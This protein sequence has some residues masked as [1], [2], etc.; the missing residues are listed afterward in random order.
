[1]SWPVPISLFPGGRTQSVNVQLIPPGTKF[2]DRWNQ[3][4]VSVNK[5]F[6]RGRVKLRPKVE[7]FNVL[8]SS[9][10]LAELQTF[11]TSLGKPSETLQGR[12]VKLGA[13]VTF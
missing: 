1:M 5:T 8:N 13:S 4:D 7:V 6:T 11:G 9:V 10:V 12:F 3:L 2:A